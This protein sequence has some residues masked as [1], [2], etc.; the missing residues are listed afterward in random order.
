[1]CVCVCVR[2]CVRVRVCVCAC[3]CVWVSVCVCACVC[4]FLC[5][6]VC[7]SVCECGC[8]FTYVF[9]VKRDVYSVKRVLHDGVL[10]EH[11]ICNQSSI[12]AVSHAIQ[13][14]HA[15]CSFQLC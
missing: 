1:M 8:V 12:V 14:S 6:N 13:E 3:A 5:T 7:V 15:A 4:V 2:A 10:R 9:V 11:Y